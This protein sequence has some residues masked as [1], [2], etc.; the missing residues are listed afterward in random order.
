MPAPI[1]GM[2]LE[3][4]HAHSASDDDNAELRDMTRRFWI[5]L[6]L[7]VPV[8]LISMGQMVP[9]MRDEVMSRAWTLE[10]W[11]ELVLCHAGR[12]VGRLALLCA[13]CAF[14]A[15]APP[16]YVYAHRARNRRGL[17]L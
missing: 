8:V 6:A 17:L 1:C 16:Q 2:A 4:V 3:P 12:A 9:V 10:N 11:A 5:G 13:G 7:T 15:H 14:A